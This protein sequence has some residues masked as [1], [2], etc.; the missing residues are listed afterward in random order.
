MSPRKILLPS[1]L[2]LLTSTMSVEG[3]LAQAPMPGPAIATVPLGT[4]GLDGTVTFQRQQFPNDMEANFPDPG[5][6]IA[7]FQGYTFTAPNSA[8]ATIVITPTNGNNWAW[9]FTTTGI[10]NIGL[11]GAVEDVGQNT[12]NCENMPDPGNSPTNG[13]WVFNPKAQPGSDQNPVTVNLNVI[14]GHA[15]CIWLGWG[16]LNTL[17]P[18]SGTRLGTFHIQVTVPPPVNC[19]QTPTNPVCVPGEGAP[20]PLWAYAVVALLLLWVGRRRLRLN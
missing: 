4:G 10:S 7:D 15:Y 18:G 2:L 9:Y 16:T 8:V 14:Q 19:A 11:I 12:Q 3:A 17:N 20:L 13:D 5:G 6:E 1:A